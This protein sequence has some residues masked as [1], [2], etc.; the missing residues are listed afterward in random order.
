VVV[1]AAVVAGEVAAVVA[2]LVA[3]VVA[4]AVVATVVAGGRV[5][6]AAPVPPPMGGWVRGVVEGGVV[7]GGEVVGPP[8]G[9]VGLVVGAAVPTLL[10]S[11]WRVTATAMPAASRPTMNTVSPIRRS[12]LSWSHLA[13]RP[14][15]GKVDSGYVVACCD[16]RMLRSV[17]SG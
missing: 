14:A 16:S 2:G 11:P 9:T 17:W 10:D 13:R 6:G 1:G 7:T 3:A 5:V 4:G 8:E 15:Q 12:R